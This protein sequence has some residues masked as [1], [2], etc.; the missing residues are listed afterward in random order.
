MD[1]KDFFIRIY[2]VSLKMDLFFISG[3]IFLAL[4]IVL[5]WIIQ[6]SLIITSE[7]LGPLIMIVK[8][9]NGVFDTI[10]WPYLDIIKIFPFTKCFSE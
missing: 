10:P 3:Q 7:R 5:T 4:N 9:G 8:I 2:F 6:S 1:A